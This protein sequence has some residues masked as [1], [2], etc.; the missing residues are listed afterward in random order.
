MR[1]VYLEG[2]GS[3][4]SDF[5][6][7][8]H[9][10]RAALAV[11]PP[12][13]LISGLTALAIKK[14]AIP[15]GF[16]PSGPIDVAVPWTARRGPVRPE[17]AAH[18]ERVMPG[19][20]DPGQLIAEP[21]HCWA[22]AA[23]PHMGVEPWTPGR[24]KRATVR[25]SF[26][27]PAK[28]AFLQAVQLGD[29]LV[30]RVNPMIAHGEFAERIADWGPRRGAPLVR[31]LFRHVKAGTDS[32]TETWLRLAVVDAGFPEPAV[33]H[34]VRI[35]GRDRYLD[36][37]WPDAGIALEYHGRQHFNDP[38]QSYSD[39]YRRGGLQEM[40]WIV[41]EATYEDL[42]QPAGMLARLATAFRR[43]SR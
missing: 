40:G 42:R 18:R 13:S 3:P 28:Q 11:S 39:V 34:L 38:G 35:Q 7:L 10:G 27:D 1:G 14:V 25:G 15:D 36:L 19:L 6:R 31:E 22:R 30:R 21:A 4:M 2:S 9:R 8:I 16:D 5:D 43:V 23:L 26:V 20:W 24:E 37:S 29:A 12:G 32:L 33:N 17:I 41:L